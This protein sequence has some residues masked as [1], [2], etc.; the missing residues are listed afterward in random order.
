MKTYRAVYVYIHVFL[1]SALVGGE[2]PASRPG[3]FTPGKEPPV[4]IGYEAGASQNRSGRRGNEKNF[5]PAG[6]RTSAPRSSRPYPVA[7]P[8]G[9]FRLH[10]LWRLFFLTLFKVYIMQSILRNKTR[11]KE[12]RNIKADFVLTVPVAAGRN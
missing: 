10:Y 4:H 11:K 8:T 12:K 1:T 7:M 3:R 6:T 2:W 5:A 9:L